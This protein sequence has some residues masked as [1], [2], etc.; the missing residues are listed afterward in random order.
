MLLRLC[1]IWLTLLLAATVPARTGRSHR[2]HVCIITC[3]FWGLPAAGG[4]A[5]AYHLLASSLAEKGTVRRPV[6]FLGATQQVTLCHQIQQNFS[7]GSVHFTCLEQAHFLPEVVETYPYERVG[8]AV[9]RWLQ[10]D[11]AMCDVIHTHEWGGGM[12]QL[13]AYVSMRHNVD[14]RLIVEPH[15]GHYWS[16]QGARQRP[17]DLFTLRVDDHERLTMHL[18]D[19]V[20]SPSAYMLAHL[21]Q[22]GWTLPSASSVIPNIV[23][24]AA[25]S[26]EYRQERSVWRLAFFG[27]LEERKG[28]KLFCD[29][30]EMLLAGTYVDLEVMF[31]GGE[32]RIDMRPSVMYLEERTADWRIPVDIGASLPR[33]SALDRLKIP[34]IMV[35]FASLVENLPFALAEACIEQIPFITFNVGGVAELLDPVVHADIIVNNISA[36]ALHERLRFFLASGRIQT[37]V[38]TPTVRHG[39]DLWH[40]LH[41]EYDKGRTGRQVRLAR[42]SLAVE[43]VP[44]LP[45][46]ASMKLKQDL[47]KKT[48]KT[49][50]LLLVP[51]NFASP[52]PSDLSDIS[53]LAAQMPRL[54]GS[55]KLGALVFGARLPNKS[56]SYPSSPTWI[57]YHGKEPVCV[58]NAP[59]LVLNDVFCSSF[60]AEAGDFT[61]F[62]T[63]LLIRH[64][65]LSGLSTTAFPEPQFLLQ[66]FSQTGSGCFSD[67]IPAFRKLSGDHAA[68]QLGPS[69][70]VL[71]S[72]HLAARPR[73]V[74][75]LRNDFDKFQGQHGWQY[76]T[77]DEHGKINRPVHFAY[78][79]HASLVHT[80][81]TREEPDLDASGER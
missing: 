37:S 64:L 74:T 71:M 80:C 32:S 25:T 24:E 19:D 55:R 14:R 36:S 75:S 7:S 57:I 1:L 76:V 56:L 69:E 31:I 40:L 21:R 73:P 54:L 81:R 50:A 5:T 8:L 65:K 28:I 12:Q 33:R 61:T 16:S 63:W 18:A 49:S 6:T 9:V 42:P 48:S 52:S 53:F 29:A 39:E 34:G 41:A 45:G 11:G 26:S 67:R 60:L 68:N 17:T 15:G 13:A 70:E 22:R 58:E 62:Y 38:L 46:Q 27:R 79:V 59:L 2:S 35:V 44:L 78:L 3:D 4:T 20:K 72:Q 10:S 30:V 47:C 23:P 43:V 66:N 51:P 77:F